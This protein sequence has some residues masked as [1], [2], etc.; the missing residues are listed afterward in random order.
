MIPTLSTDVL[1]VG[2]GPAGASAARSAAGAGYRVVAV[3]RKHQAG[4]PVQCA[5]F[6]PTML[7]PTVDA[8]N[9]AKCQRIESM[10][11]FVE[12]APPDR[13]DN[14]PGVM[15]DRAKFDQQL[16]AAATAAGAECRFG[17]T[18]S[19]LETDGTVY[20][21]TGEQIKPQVLIGADGPRSRIGGAIDSKNC[22]IVVAR[23]LTVALPDT[24]SATDIFLSS[25][26][27]GGYGW[28]FPRGKVANLGIGVAPES[29]EALT[30]LLC[31]L[32]QSMV[33][34]GRV[35]RD[36]LQRTGGIIPVGGMIKPHGKL[37]EVVVLLCGDAAGLTNPITGAGISSAVLSGILAGDSAHSWLEGDTASAMD[38]AEELAEL[39]G[40]ASA[41]AVDRRRTLLS[42]YRSGPGPTQL[43]L[44]SAWI[45]YPEYWAA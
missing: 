39:F 11:T 20:L 5:E 43:D 22:D 17:A 9:H 18:V 12:N 26:Y 10:Q 30:S 42:R 14:F 19:K 3:D 24:H 1:V 31:D 33:A 32:H 38:Y 16:V 21:S 40:A 41:R 7:S 29:L 28:L 15:V 8:V 13:K 35:G 34:A 4:I 23:Q 44:R 6:V 27:R 45:A 25:D 37:G 36:V 2:L